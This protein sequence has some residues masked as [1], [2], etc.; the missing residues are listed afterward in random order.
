MNKVFT[1]I[2]IIIILVALTGCNNDSFD[3]V[4]YEG[5]Q[6]QVG[7]LGE[8][9][10]IR[11]NNVN[12]KEITFND[13]SEV[14]VLAK[15]DA[16][17]VTKENLIQ[18]AN[19]EYSRVYKTAAIPFF[20]IQSNKSYIPFINEEL[21]YS[22]VP[23]LSSDSFATGYFQDGDKFQYWGFGLYNDKINSMNIKDVYTRIFKT[24]ELI[25]KK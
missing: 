20:F 18:A 11:E 21:E 22:E 10:A 5:K 16:V 3:T 9:P 8:T 2:S 14:K 19:K 6:L 25:D 15:F 17:L 1:Y 12:F 23:E 7:V 4:I 24:I 13:L